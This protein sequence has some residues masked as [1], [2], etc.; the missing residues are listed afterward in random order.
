MLIA[1]VVS[2]MVCAKLPEQVKL[3]LGQKQGKMCNIRIERLVVQITM[4]QT[5]FK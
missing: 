5:V 4:R 2:T 3:R 1:S